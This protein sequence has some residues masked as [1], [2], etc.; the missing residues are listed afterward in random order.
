M[1]ASILIIDDQITALENLEAQLKDEG[2]KVYTALDGEEGLR[3]CSFCKPNVVILDIYMPGMRGDYVAEAIKNN[4]ETR[5]TPIIFLTSLL[6]KKDVAGY[7]QMWGRY[8]IAKPY[9]FDELRSLL[10]RIICRK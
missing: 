10:N 2:Y 3:K 1:S 8:F 9:Q 5:D 6:N 7:A 4:P